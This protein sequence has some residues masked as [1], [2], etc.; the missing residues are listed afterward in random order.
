LLPIDYKFI[1]YLTKLGIKRLAGK[2]IDPGFVKEI[3]LHGNPG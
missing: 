2:K 1:F 3:N